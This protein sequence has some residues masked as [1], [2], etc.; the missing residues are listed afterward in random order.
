M[1]AGVLIHSFATTSG[2]NVTYKPTK[3]LFNTAAQTRCKQN[4]SGIDAQLTEDEELWETKETGTFGQDGW[5]ISTIDK[6]FK[7]DD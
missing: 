1:V 4:R 7:K 3:V 6:A 5:S 2:Y